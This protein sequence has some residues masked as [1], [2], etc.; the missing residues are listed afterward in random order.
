MHV[1]CTYCTP[2]LFVV[3]AAGASTTAHTASSRAQYV[4]LLLLMRPLQ[5]EGSTC[6]RPHLHNS[7]PFHKAHRKWAS[8][9]LCAG[10]K[11]LHNTRSTPLSCLEGWIRPRPGSVQAEPRERKKEVSKNGHDTSCCICCFLVSIH[12]MLSLLTKSIQKN[13]LEERKQH[14][15]TI[16]SWPKNTLA[17]A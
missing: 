11:I 14:R 6:L 10:P 17:S 2:M 8:P 16:P 7:T 3:H 4:R 1:R 5:A 9:S 12:S 13:S 15:A